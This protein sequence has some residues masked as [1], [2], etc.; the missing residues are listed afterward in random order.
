MFSFS[1]IVYIN[2]KK[3][4]YTLDEDNNRLYEKT[5]DTYRQMFCNDIDYW[6][7]Q[8]INKK[9]SPQCRLIFLT[10]EYTIRSHHGYEGV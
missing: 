8:S 2:R 5:L 4:I 9:I 10:D 3:Y 7:F 6:Y 1:N